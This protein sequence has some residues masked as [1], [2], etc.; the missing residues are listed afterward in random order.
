MKDIYSS[1]PPM[2][3]PPKGKDHA[4]PDFVGAIAD[5]GQSTPNASS[6]VPEPLA[7][8]GS[9]FGLPIP[10]LA[11][12]TVLEH[13]GIPT[14]TVL[15]SD[16]ATELLADALRDGKIEARVM[17]DLKTEVASAVHEL[18]W[19]IVDGRQLPARRLVQGRPLAEW[20]SLD[21]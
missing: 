5:P 4:L 7:L 18:E 14:P 6:R 11:S 19:A 13:F 8:T 9:P 10:S 20:L 2:F 16:R 17:A 21:D 15:N 12:A 3:R 1:L